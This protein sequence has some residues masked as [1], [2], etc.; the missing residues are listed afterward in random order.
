[1]KKIKENLTYW[2]GKLF[3]PAFHIPPIEEKREIID[4][5]IRFYKPEY[6]I[7]TG[8]FMGDTVEFV[9]PKLQKIF[10]IELSEEL[11]NNAKDR[12]VNDRNIKIIQGDSSI[13][14]KT[15]IQQLKGSALF[16]LDG[17][18]SSEFFI[19]DKFIRTAKG[20]INT[21]IVKE[22]EIILSSSLMP[23]IL[24]DDARLFNGKDDYPT[25][26]SIK[27][28]IT[29]TKGKFNVF[30]RKDIIHILPVQE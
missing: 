4:Q 22:L 24:I 7:E 29:T 17:H 26:K 2:I 15:L 20:E 23:I 21:P 11:A 3:K 30:I 28:L 19:K 6:F 18:Y 10:S 13:E 8:T 9:K 12:F 5:Y 27:S 25:L 14:L 1:M 16:W